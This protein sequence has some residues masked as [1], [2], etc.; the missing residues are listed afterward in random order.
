MWR[1]LRLAARTLRKSPAFASAAILTLALG[2]GANAAIFSFVDRLVIHQFPEV[3]RPDRVVWLFAN[4]GKLDLDQDDVTAADFADWRTQSKSFEAFTPL[5]AQDATLTGGGQPE[6]LL[7]MSV[8]R[9]FFQVFGTQPQLG[10]IFSPEEETPASGPV[11]LLGTGFWKRRFGGDPQIV[12]KKVVINGQSMTVIGVMP[13]FMFPRQADVFFP[14]V[15]AP[16]EWQN[17]K[18]GAFAALA[19][20]REGS[21]LEAA[22][23]ELDVISKRLEAQYPDTN[24]ELRVHAVPLPE[25]FNTRTPMFVLLAGV[26]FVLLIACA[27]VANLQIARGMARQREIAVRQAI[28]ASRAKLVRQLLCETLLLALA[29]AAIGCVLATVGIDALRSSLPERFTERMPQLRELSVNRYVLLF[30]LALALATTIVSGLVPALRGSRVDL[31]ASLKEGAAGAGVGLR[32]QRLAG[33]LVA[34]QVMLAMVLLAGAGITLRSFVALTEVPLGFR[35]DGLFTLRM[36]LDQMEQAEKRHQFV[37]RVAERLAALPGVESIAVTDRLPMTDPGSGGLPF[38]IVGDPPVADD[39]RPQANMH[40]VS[41]TFFHTFQIPLV[42]GRNFDA[43]DRHD[44]P[45]VVLI[46]DALARRLFSG[47][48]PIG[49]RLHMGDARLRDHEI[50]GV[51]GDVAD[52]RSRGHALGTMY[53]PYAQDP[54]GLAIVALRSPEPQAAGLAAAAAIH[55]IDPDV[56]V[57]HPATMLRVLAEIRSGATI[58]TWLVGLMGSIALVLAALGIYGLVSYSVGQR[59]REIGIRMAL[60]AQTTAVV[61]GMMRRAIVLTSVGLALGFLLS[62]PMAGGLR[63]L[64]YMPEHGGT[65]GPMVGVALLLGTIATL[66]AFLPARRAA[67]IDPMIAL[68]SE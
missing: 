43:R 41:P 26:A 15:L 5:N 37:D 40:W 13:P 34:G 49:R 11:T 1:D 66:A 21:S 51:V 29:G 28:G 58:M 62:V 24:R 7:A 23:G 47:R 20:L 32:R 3:S 17:R 8:S 33:V 67:R 19:R 52:P 42:R 65:W 60:G 10:R 36:P 35:A 50:I 6:R 59:T 2:I 12:G 56:V 48:D 16:A 25:V 31:T 63:S 38:S 4:R 57:D 68:R 22:Q 45:P 27:N 46:S 30:S 53:A 64:L 44:S 9:D 39:E 18:T 55:E 14:T 61:R 54:A